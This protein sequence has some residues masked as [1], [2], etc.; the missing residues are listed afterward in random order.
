M[1]FLSVVIALVSAAQ[2]L[3]PSN[4]RAIDPRSTQQRGRASTADE[5][6]KRPSVA[7]RQAPSPVTF[8]DVAAQCGVTFKHEA[9]PT[10]QKYLLETMSSG[11]AIFDYDNDGRMDL[12][13]TNG[14]RL[15][16]PMTK[17][18]LPDKSDPKF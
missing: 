3:A 18:A 1:K 15:M 10:S 7:A 9:S 16:D 12:F 8:T 14:A 4:A 2:A 5:S 6:S 11:V 13:F 17:G